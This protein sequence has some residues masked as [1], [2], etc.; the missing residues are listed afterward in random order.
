MKIIESEL[1]TVKDLMSEIFEDSILDG[2]LK[3]FVKNGSK[4]IRSS[5]VILFFKS[6]NKELND[7][8]YK[9]LSAGE[10]I[11]NASL[12]HDDVL[13]DAEIRRN[14]TTIAKKFSSKISILAGDYLLSS[15]I[16]S[17]LSLENFE[18]LDLFR[19]CT[20][21]MSE[22]EIKQFF[23]RGKIPTK[24]EYID[25]CRKK[26]AELFSTVLETS[27]IVLDSD[28]VLAKKFGEIFGICFQIK[29]DMNKDSATIDKNNGIYT[30]IDIFGIEKTN[31]LLDNYKEELINIVQD[32]DDNIY[33]ERL[34][35]LIKR[36]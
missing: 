28:R 9:V 36:L 33:K 3:S 24:D 1:N 35:D 18:I 4:L 11:H 23:L 21:K 12:L 6:Q 13:D 26:T 30:A 16:E 7:I 19:I 15:A 31:V 2:E 20:Q 8:F 27:A 5:L 17:L 32:F 34:K 25:I 10:F 14:S 29:N 22:A